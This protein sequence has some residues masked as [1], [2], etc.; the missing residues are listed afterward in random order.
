MQQD[1][2]YWIAF[3]RVPSVGRVR[4]GVLEERFGSLAAAWQASDGELKSCGLDASV[5]SA[6]RSV[7]VTIDPEAEYERVVRSGIRALTWHDPDYPRGLR[8]IDDLP[9]V[10]YVKGELGREDG[11]S[12][13]VVGTRNPT[14]YGREVA[15]HLA[16]DLAQAGV[17]VISGLARGID[18][19][20][21]RAA[22]EAGGRT[23]AVMGSGADIIYPSEHTGLARE[24]AS[25]GA[26]LTE[27]PVGT[28]PEA[29]HFPRRNRLLSGLS[30]GTLVVEAGEGS[31]TLSTVKFALEQGREVFCVPGS[32]YS[33]ASRLTNRL[34]Q[35]GA[36][37]VMGV[38]DILE[39]LNLSSLTAAQVEIPGLSDAESVDEATLLEALDFEPCHV[40][41]ISRQTGL[42]VTLVTG[43]LAV[44]EL[45]GQV[46]QVGRMNY[47]R[48][49]ETPGRYRTNGARLT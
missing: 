28:K 5:V 1:L 18:G 26:L 39:E 21:H 10:L 24:I 17:T 12:V 27:H 7:R 36:K 44:L 19:I 9:P 22:L 37:L 16:G 40:D 13:T 43:T 30:L 31:G 35:E 4:I 38:E 42:P 14:A 8:E 48:A 15:R 6:I 33:P 29:R 46:K 32:I 45:K 23:L 34:V 41:D 49:R 25:T 3:S 2:P 11:R 20:A 47:V